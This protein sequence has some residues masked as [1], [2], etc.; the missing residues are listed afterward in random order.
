LRAFG[1]AGRVPRRRKG[2]IRGLR[3]ALA[4]TLL[5]IALHARISDAEDS[6]PIRPI[7]LIVPYSA[8]GDT[9]VIA[10]RLALLLSAAF[11]QQVVID[12]R[13]G[14]NGII[15]TELVAKAPADG[16]TLLMGSTPTHAINQWLYRQLPYDPVKDFVPISEV[17]SAPMILV[18]NPS[19]GVKNFEELIALAKAKPGQLSFAS[20]GIGSPQ[21]LAG[22][23]LKILA[24]VDINH[25]PYKGGGPALVDV[26]AGQVPM[27]FAFTATA[28][29]FVNSG[30]LL[31]LAATT[32]ERLPQ[33]PLIPS[34]SQTG[35][36]GLEMS[37]WMGMFAPAGTPES[38]VNRLNAE[39]AKAMN[40]RDIAE[41]LYTLGSEV[42]TNSP[43]QF[44]AY[45]RAE[46]EKWGKLV[47]ASGAKVE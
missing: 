14:A 44:A 47:K 34:V 31:G 19:T 40:S 20:G 28:L 3:T 12:N 30:R 38:V 32:R 41:A 45:I 17:A 43:Q 22:E 26:V 8:G 33:A 1:V 18:V 4:L 29:P 25:V 2:M 16:Y 10:R 9:D 24:G 37:A 6:Y 5:A 35:L 21:H 7:R 42:V 46:T 11:G 13:P 23:M 15:G 27:M 36:P 39:I